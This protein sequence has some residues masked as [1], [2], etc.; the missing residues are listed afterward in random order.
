MHLF[1]A[2]LLLPVAANAGEVLHS[3]IRVIEGVY[4]VRVDVHIAAP[5]ATVLRFLTDYERLTDIS[6]TIKESRIV[7]T[8]S[9]TRHRVQTVIRACIL[10]FC[11]SV[12]Q[13]QDVEQQSARLLVATYL[14]DESDF[15]QGNARWQ[16]TESNGQTSMMFSAT[17]EPDFWVPP[18]I[19]PWMIQ[20]RIVNELLASATHMEAAVQSAVAP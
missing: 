2:L 15:R 3:S 18:L 12:H 13:V 11:R 7:Q 5:P 10:F 17:L 4:E 16:L 8:F 6:P 1:V 9:P 14:P 20:R 19:G